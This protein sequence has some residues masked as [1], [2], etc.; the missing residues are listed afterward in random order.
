MSQ[1]NI[2][3]LVLYYSDRA[4]PCAA[5]ALWVFIPLAGGFQFAFYLCIFI[6]AWKRLSSLAKS[7]FFAA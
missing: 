3:F 4:H 2:L 1:E 6:I 7:K 5:R